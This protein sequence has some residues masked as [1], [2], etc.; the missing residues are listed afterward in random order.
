[1]YVAVIG[2]GDGARPTDVTAA[3]QVGRLLAAAGA[4]VVTGGLGG[5]MSGATAGAQ[6]RGGV[7]LDLLPGRSRGKSDATVVVPTDLGEGRNVLVVRSADAI[8]AI[9]GSWGTLSEIALARR[10]G[11]PVV[12]L[13]GWRITDGAGADV[14]PPRASSPQDAVALVLD[15]VRDASGTME[16]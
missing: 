12:C 16:E 11:V 3:R 14:T 10:T 9:G 15:L 8:I 1:V 2:P 4:V 13:D 7:T 6:E 5:V